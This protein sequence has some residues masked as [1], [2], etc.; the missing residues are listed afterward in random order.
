[1][2]Y[3]FTTV[4]ILS[5]ADESEGIRNLKRQDPVSPLM[6]ELHWLPLHFRITFKL[7][8]LMLGIHYGTGPKYMNELVTP[9]LSLPSRERLRSAATMN[10]DIKHIKLKFGKRSFAVSGPTAWNT[11]CKFKMYREVLKEI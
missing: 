10:Y 2:Y 11:S 4:I 1:M 9:T 7:C 6:M 3:T 8:V 5:F